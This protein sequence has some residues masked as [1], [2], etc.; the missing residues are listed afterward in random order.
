MLDNA[1][2]VV[3]ESLGVR[4]DEVTFTPSGTHAVHLGVLGLL[5]GRARHPDLQQAAALGLDE[6]QGDRADLLLASAVEHSAVLHA[7]EW[8]ARRGGRLETLPVHAS[9]RVTPASLT[10]AVAEHGEPAV[11][12][13]QSANH[14]VGVCQPV[15]E[16][17]GLPT[18]AESLEKLIS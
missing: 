2:A 6:I 9:G 4:S 5:A 14:E 13:L 3:A 12:A 18:A 11:V 16:V 17:A 7:G 10:E 1:R 8:H 15:A